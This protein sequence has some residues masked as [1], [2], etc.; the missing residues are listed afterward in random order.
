MQDNDNNNNEPK[1]KLKPRKAMVG[2]LAIF[3]GLLLGAG[4][5]I[6]YYEST[7]K[8][9]L[10][11]SAN[12]QSGLELKIAELTGNLDSLY[13]E[14]EQLSYANDENNAATEDYSNTIENVAESVMPSVVG[15]RTITVQ[16][17]TS[18]F[19]GGGSMSQEVEGIGTGVIVSADGLILT[20]QHVVSDN[21]KSITVTLLDGSEYDAEVVYA[22]EAMDLAVIKIEATG[23]SAA[24]LGNSDDIS[25][26][27]ITITIGN[28]L[29]LEYQRSVTAGIVSALGRNIRLEQYAYATNL[30]Q[31]DAAINS[32]NSGG[33]L[34][35]SSGEVIGINSY[36]LSSGEGMGFAIPINAALPIINQ[37]IDTGEFVQARI[38]A[39][40][41]DTN[42]YALLDDTQ[43]E[44]LGINDIEYD[45]GLLIVTMNE[46]SN[47]FANGLR[48][49]DILV[50]VDG[51]DI[52]TL[53]ELRSLLYSHLP[54]DT[55]ELTILRDG[56]TI[57]L[58][59]TLYEKSE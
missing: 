42:I 21:P 55:I 23:L 22:D 1:R 19:F 26:G 47:A 34:L 48:V 43:L 14:V 49:N 59:V 20:N 46:D 40:L 18:F 50:D 44:Q 5:T 37:V 57:V 41:I 15:V 27:E 45:R 33:P 30:I 6:L 12:Q 13:N 31:T 7:F 9:Q 8:P 58:P 39:N 4:G 51:T 35:N 32:G 3:M 53:L 25:V 54:G 52:D 56:E 29:G 2:M 36:K 17:A 38:G 16:T 10:A 28:P 24:K 11:E